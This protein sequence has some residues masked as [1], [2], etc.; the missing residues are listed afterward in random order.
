MLLACGFSARGEWEHDVPAKQPD[1]NA[2]RD[3]A[4]APLLNKKLHLLPEYQ[5][6]ARLDFGVAQGRLVWVDH[7]AIPSGKRG[8][9]YGPCA[10]S[11][12]RLP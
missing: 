7:V 12:G 2:A 1:L 6:I 11:H 8:T 9:G 4:L 5:G 3:T 10:L